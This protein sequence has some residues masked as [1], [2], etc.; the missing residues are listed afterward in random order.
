MSLATSRPVSMLGFDSRFYFDFDGVFNV[1]KSLYGDAVSTSVRLKVDG[2]KKD[3]SLNYSPSLLADVDALR[4]K[5]NAE[6]VW[7][8]SWCDNLDILKAAKV[9]GG[10]LDGR[11]LS[12]MFTPWARLSK[13]DRN[14]WKLKA[15]VDDLRGDSVPFVWA[16]DEALTVK[17]FK[18]TVKDAYPDVPK[19]L[20]APRSWGGLSRLDVAAMDNFLTASLSA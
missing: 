4:V 6:L 13:A 18:T 11:V 15:V 12:G 20:V 3:V 10:L 17:S 16:D 9:M 14:S 5:H 7:V 2:V 1:D 19:L 8:S